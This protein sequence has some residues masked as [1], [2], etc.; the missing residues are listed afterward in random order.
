MSLC[1][2]LSANTS[3]ADLIDMV[4]KAAV[5]L[6][7]AG[8]AEILAWAVA[9]FSPDLAVAC[10][11]QDGVVVDLAIVADPGIEVAFLD[12]GFHFPETLETARLLRERYDLNL[13]TIRAAVDAA[14]WFAQ[15]TEACCDARK[16][17][18]LEDYLAGKRA[19]ITGLRR[20]ESASRTT[21]RAVEWDARRQVVKV[22]PIVAWTDEEVE[23]YIAVHD[24]IVNPLRARGYASIGCAPCT[25]PGTG[26]EGRW[27][28]SEQL[29]CGL[30]APL[31]PSRRRLAVDVDLR[32][33]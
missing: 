26:R 28:G 25:V 24:I 2:P 27:K 11:M 30:H 17:A 4:E 14:S 16:V 7:G 3:P 20:D 5:D 18:P 31:E 29:E 1:A 12:T 6:D 22:N 9:E 32:S 33:A 21:A 19:W 15:G 13:R 10:S 23:R 8:A